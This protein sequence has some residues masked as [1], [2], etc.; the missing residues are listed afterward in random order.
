MTV[1]CTLSPLY[2]DNVAEYRVPA[3]T[4]STLA[5]L[6]SHGHNNRVQLVADQA[7]DRGFHHSDVPMTSSTGSQSA[8]GIRVIIFICLFISASAVNRIQIGVN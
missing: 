3:P 4:S 5:L 1:G 6:D 7:V 2:V 8:P